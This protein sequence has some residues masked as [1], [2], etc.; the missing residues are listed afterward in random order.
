MS[1]RDQRTTRNLIREAEGEL[2]NSPTARYLTRVRAVLIVLKGFSVAEASHLLQIPKRTIFLWAHRAYDGGLTTLKEKP[3][4]GRPSKVKPETVVKLI[5]EAS[6]DPLY[7]RNRALGPVL[8]RAF[9]SQQGVNMSVRQC[10][11][12]I[13][14]Y[15]RK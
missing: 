11:R 3:R 2:T 6:H 13:A 8:Q 7:G 9:W 15:C 4:P 10:Q 5:E 12:L 1:K 14:K